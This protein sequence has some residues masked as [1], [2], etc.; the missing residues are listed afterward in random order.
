MH[1]DYPLMHFISPKRVILLF[2]DSRYVFNL[3]DGKEI[4]FELPM[5]DY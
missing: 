1:V 2:T 3:H 5:K 4:E